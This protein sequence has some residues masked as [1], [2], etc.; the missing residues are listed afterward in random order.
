MNGDF[1]SLSSDSYYTRCRLFIFWLAAKDCGMAGEI[2]YKNAFRVGFLI[3][4]P[5]GKNELYVYI[6]TISVQQG[7]ILSFL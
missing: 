2:P 3:I 5:R 7:N 6:H 4:S 1:V